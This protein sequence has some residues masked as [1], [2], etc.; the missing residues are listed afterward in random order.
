MKLSIF[1][2]LCWY[3]W[4]FSS[5]NCFFISLLI[6][7]YWSFFPYQFVGSLCYTSINRYNPSV[8]FAYTFYQSVFLFFVLVYGIV[9]HNFLLLLFQ[10]IFY[11]CLFLYCFGCSCREHLSPLLGFINLF[12]TFL[13][14]L[15]CLAY[16]LGKITKKEWHKQIGS[17]SLS[18]EKLEVG[19]PGLVWWLHSAIRNADSCVFLFSDP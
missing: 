13:L 8:L 3:F 5:L 18:N 11:V 7:F 9:Y 17:F 12:L 15:C 4:C 6:F 14:T 19:C 1:W 10:L 16:P 2:Y